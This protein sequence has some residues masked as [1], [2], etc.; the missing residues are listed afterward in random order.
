MSK[1]VKNLLQQEATKILQQKM[2][3]HQQN[4]YN[5]SH[6][7]HYGGQHPQGATT[8]YPPTHWNQPMNQPGPYPPT[9]P[10]PPQGMGGTQ[11][12]AGFAPQQMPF[13]APQT[14][15]SQGGGMYPTGNVPPYGAPPQ[16]AYGYSVTQT[17]YSA[18]G[19]HPYQAGAQMYPANK[20]QLSVSCSS[21]INKD[22]FSKSDPVCILF[23]K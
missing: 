4:S 7:Q 9:K 20:V 6:P 23:E 13:P 5:S 17:T 15:P 11:P 2:H 14:F 22:T 19:N 8:N 12:Y 18:S 3:G 21:L 16:P 10:Y 1:K